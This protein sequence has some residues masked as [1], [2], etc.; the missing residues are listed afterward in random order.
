MIKITLKSK[1]LGVATNSPKIVLS[2]PIAKTKNAPYFAGFVLLFITLFFGGSFTSHA[3]TITFGTT[4]TPLQL[5][6][7]I[8]NTLAIPAV[9]IPERLTAKVTIPTNTK[10]FLDTLKTY[11]QQTTQW[12]MVSKPSNHFLVV[13]FNNKEIHYGSPTTD[14]SLISPN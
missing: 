10:P 14:N 11:S 7:S 1:A 8:E 3:S 6:Y 5:S 12:L 4:V 9:S 2:Q 13:P